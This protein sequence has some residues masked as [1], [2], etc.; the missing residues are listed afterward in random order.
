MEKL[1]HKRLSWYLEINNLLSPLQSGYRNNRSTLDHL[2]RLE[3]FIRQAFVNEEHLSA[4]FFDLEKAFD[5][6]W[7]HGIMK[8]LHNL[9][10]RGNLPKFIENFLKN[11]SFHVKVGS[12][13]SDP[14]TQEEGV[15]QGSILSPLLFEI[16]INSITDNLNQNIDSSLYVDDF[17]ICYKS[18]ANIDI[19]ERQ[20]QQQLKKL[21]EWANQNG[22]KFSPSKT[23]TVHFC[24]KRSCIKKH[25]LKLYNKKIPVK[26]ET[27]F[28]GV[29][30]DKKLSFQPHIK[31]LRSRC[32]SALNAL[33]IL[34]SPEWGGDRETLLHLY[35]SL[36]RSKLDYASQ[37]YGS[38]RPSYL[39]TLN[40]VQNEGLRLA[41]GA[42]RTSPIPSLHAEAY[43]P[44]IHIRRKQL[45][46]QYAIKLSSTPENPTYKCVFEINNETKAKFERKP[47][48]I[49]PFGLRV[50]EDLAELK[51]SKDSTSNF[52]LSDTPFW[53][54]SS[55]EI[56]LALTNFKKEETHPDIFK[57]EYNE[58]IQK[59]HSYETIF[60]DGSKS[61]NAVG[62]AAVHIKKNKKEKDEEK[63]QQRLPVDA[64]ITS[65][66]VGALQ[67]AISI[68]TRSTKTQFLILSD[69]LS[70]LQ[71][72]KQINPIDTRI[73][74]LKLHIHLLINKGKKI[75]F[76]WIPS[77]I[78][79]EGNERADT[80]AKKALNLPIDPNKNPKLPYSDYRPKV[81]K[82]T[83]SLWNTEWEEEKEKQNKLFEIKP[84]LKPRSPH[85]LSRKESVVLTRLK[86]GHTKLTH[87]HL[88][89]KEEAPICVGCNSNLTVKHILLDCVDFSNSRFKYFKS[90][91]L[92]AL[93][94][95]ID[96]RKIIAFISEIGLLKKM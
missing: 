58:L 20:L 96:P 95:T 53:Q 25:E 9:N 18:K 24:R 47:N 83:L 19:I 30:F 40:T 61:D 4:I 66:E 86:I 74:C 38:A 26:D 16:K 55:P 5:T 49:K 6:T 60:T 44:P 11:R 39:K 34:A 88:L 51:F 37:I 67:E 62:S 8:D 59:Y 43:E 72:L 52:A 89:A 46:L 23:V 54:M 76:T 81:K 7:K 70:C 12:S 92:K 78:G 75:V 17:L 21:E 65:A 15:P 10:L 22:F 73:L 31:N 94:D 45:S 32:I 3:T 69:S 56:N 14:H 93:F 57:K 27:P 90:E 71:A 91:S 2:V 63:L 28:L 42:Y 87:Q 68:I 77:H 33:K 79:I 80:L 29:I 48:E 64:S 13:L 85:S 35:R 1:I 84:K 50:L 36:V 82:Y 41:L